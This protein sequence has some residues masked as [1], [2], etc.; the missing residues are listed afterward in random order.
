M[1][2]SAD[3]AKLRNDISVIILMILKRAMGW[4]DIDNAL[5]K[6]RILDVI[7]AT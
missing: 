2:S 5:N 6:L 4:T 7:S 3:G 1:T